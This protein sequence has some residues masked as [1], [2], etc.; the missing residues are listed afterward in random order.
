MHGF[1]AALFVTIGILVRDL[2][3]KLLLLNGAFEQ[4]VGV[5]ADEL[6]GRSGYDL[7]PARI[8][9]RRRS[10]DQTIMRT[11]SP[12]T[13]EETVEQAGEEHFLLASA[14][15][16]IDEYGDSSPWPGSKR[17]LQIERKPRAHSAERRSTLHRRRAWAESAV[18][19]GT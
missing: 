5:S 11:R 3:G 10:T 8:A 12:I 18:G 7:F 19:V 14:F 13:L 1:E 2:Q 15:P 16:L 9:E 17:I 4:R 6:R